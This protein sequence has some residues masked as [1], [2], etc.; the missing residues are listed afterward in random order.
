MKYDK[1]QIKKSSRILIIGFSIILVLL[2]VVAIN[3]LVYLYNLNQELETIVSVNN[4]KTVHLQTM[5]DAMRQRQLSIRDMMLTDDPFEVDSAWEMHRSAASRFMIAREKLEELELLENE[6]RMYQSML[7]L[8]VVGGAAQRKMVE[9]V[10]QGKTKSEI[11]DIFNRALESQGKAFSEME[12]LSLLQQENSN[13][14]LKT[15]KQNYNLIILI[16]ST[17][18]VFAFCIGLIVAIVIIRQ[19]RT[20]LLLIQEY[21][22]HLEEEVGKRTHDLLE[23]NQELENFNYSL[24]HDLRTPLRSIVSFS[25]IISHDAKE[26]LDRNDLEHFERIINAG[27]KMGKLL[28]DIGLLSKISRKE[29]KYEKVNMSELAGQVIEYLKHHDTTN[30]QV[31]YQCEADIFVNADK[32]MIK[33]VLEQLIGNAWIYTRNIKNAII[34]IGMIEKNTHPVYYVKDNGIGFNM[35]YSKKMFGQFQKL[36]NSDDLSSTGIGLA[37]VER[38]IKRSNGKVWS[39]SIPGEG[40]TFYFELPQSASPIH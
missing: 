23:I 6:S 18:G 7:K 37:I 20:Q 35:K 22:E 21:Q 33:L 19:N 17:L 34:K 32:L 16:T 8:T 39:E 11:E 9:M 10:L 1:I 40:A 28:E 30:H 31:S 15:A 5:K 13:N 24:A 12:R 25:Q 14:T 2:V 27:K 29:I 38:A 3:S 26:R 36:I 4:V